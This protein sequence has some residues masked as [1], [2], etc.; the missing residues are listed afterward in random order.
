MVKNFV[1]YYRKKK[2]I[3]QYDMARAL[4]VSPSYLCK[5][6][7]GKQEPSER[8]KE[9][10]AAFLDVTMSE[11]FPKKIVKRDIEEINHT[12]D[13]RLWAVRQKKGLKQNELAEQIGC[14]PSYLSK[15]ENGL[16]MPNEKFRKRCARILKIKETELFL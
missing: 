10:C 15:V 6:E 12:L 9:A 8:F 4:D 5:I 14:S 7:K 11:I 1:L 13:R 2:N 3:K 16:L